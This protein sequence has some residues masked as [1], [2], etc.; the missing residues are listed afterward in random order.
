MGAPESAGR[1]LAVCVYVTDPDSRDVV[2]LQPGTPVTDARIAEQIT[3]PEAWEE[4]DPPEQENTAKDESSG[5]GDAGG[6]EPASPS[7]TTARSTRKT[8]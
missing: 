4:G 3:H 1:R 2:I 8:K 7:S 6:E 5:A